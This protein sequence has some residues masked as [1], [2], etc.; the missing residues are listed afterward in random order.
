[1][2]HFIKS[3][4]GT[5]DLQTAEIFELFSLAQNFKTHFLT[6]GQFP[7]Q[8]AKK[9][10]MA[11]LFF[12]PSTRTRLSFEV[13]TLRLGGL[14]T[15]FDGASKENTSLIKGESLED[16]FWTVHAMMPD[17]I[18]VRSGDEFPLHSLRDRVQCPLINAGYGTES[19]PT[20]ALLDVFTMLENF[21]EIKSKNIL[22]IG[23]IRH[24]RVVGSHRELLPRLGARIGVVGPKH[25]TQGLES[26]IQ[27]MDKLEDGLKWA[28]VVMGLRI[29]F[30]R[31]GSQ[32]EFSREN[33][34]RDYQITKKH[35]ELM[36]EHAL[37]MHPG[38]V[39]WGVEFDP[40][41][42]ELKHFKM[43]DQKSNGVFVRAALL[44]HL[45]KSFRRGNGF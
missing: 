41:V 33:F 37:L 9:P 4:L 25:L 12:E 21:S 15:F 20:Q 17:A 44:D 26:H 8:F 22:F 18:I 6:H 40:S 31:H 13:A 45:M 36:K 34:I 14:S 10:L 43:W 35:G 42:R 7:L 32:Q 3:F 30:E 2:S 16:T 24:S 28:D 29:Q 27:V 38:P 23:D 39:N 11:L 1:M 19:H 5:Q